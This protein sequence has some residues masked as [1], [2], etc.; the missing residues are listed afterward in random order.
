MT[1]FRFLIPMMAVAASALAQ[2]PPFV[3][4]VA[5]DAMV[6]ERVAE[7]SK[8]GD[9]PRDVIRRIVEEDID[10]LRGRRNDGTYQYATYERVEANRISDEYSIQPAADTERLTKID[11]K[12]E[13]VYRLTVEVPSRRLLVTK[14][15]RVYLDRIELEYIPQ[16]SSTAKTQTVKVGAWME[17]GDAKAFDFP[18]VGRQSTARLWL[19][20]DKKQGYANVALTLQQA[21][22]AENPDSPYAD[23][24]ASEKALLRAIRNGDTDSVR[25]LANRIRL[26]LPVEGR[27]AT[28]GGTL[29]VTAPPIA[30]IPP[31]TS[32]VLPDVASE[33]QTIEDLLTGSEAER[34]TGLDRLH[35]LIRR[36]RQH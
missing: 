18:E 20:A 33:L 12:G 29:E 35:Q 2:S 17:P 21:R 25:A 19:R 26:T 22:V 5:N 11:I 10:L 30:P 34:R 9:L 23:A 6:I 31:A 15:R 14:N 28:A 32:Q 8:R 7:M 27:T 13:F 3:V 16:T 4:Q 36:L 1:R 24:V